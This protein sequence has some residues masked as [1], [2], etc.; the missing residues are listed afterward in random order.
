MPERLRTVHWSDKTPSTSE[1]QR[2]TD[3][4]R[5][6]DSLRRQ[7]GALVGSAG[8]STFPTEHTGNYEEEP[9]YR[10]ALGARLPA[11]AL[12]ELDT[13]VPALSDQANPLPTPPPSAV[14][15][16]IPTSQTSLTG[17]GLMLETEATSALE[18]R[19]HQQQC[20]I[21]NLEANLSSTHD[22]IKL[23]RANVERDWPRAPTQNVGAEVEKW[24]RLAEGFAEELEQKNAQLE[25]LEQQIGESR[26]RELDLQRQ[27]LETKH[28]QLDMDQEVEVTGNTACPGSQIVW[29]GRISEDAQPP[30]E[31]P[32]EPQ[33]LE[34]GELP[35]I[36]ER[37]FTPMDLSPDTTSV[38]FQAPIERLE[39]SL[40]A[41]NVRTECLQA[42]Q[43]DSQIAH[44]RA[45]S[46]GWGMGTFQLNGTIHHLNRLLEEAQDERDRLLNE[47]HESRAPEADHE[48]HMPGVELEEMPVATELEGSRQDSTPHDTESIQWVRRRPGDRLVRL[49][50]GEHQNRSPPEGDLARPRRRSGHSKDEMRE[51]WEIPKGQ[52]L[53]KFLLP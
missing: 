3:A 17:E 15:A 16:D 44:Q 21:D 46:E 41:A 40:I 23:L 9:T 12:P 53:R 29:E 7:R 2:Q 26:E 51:A 22:E 43:S 19:I 11:S 14:T 28:G 50:G 20:R 38:D 48:Q 24:K 13:Q 8:G 10:L 6:R 39:E 30:N 27:L 45:M 1:S 42:Q 31:M 18:T 52:W 32:C 36:H 34:D 5:R 49:P 37:F 35:T 25:R 47:L 33:S 4:R